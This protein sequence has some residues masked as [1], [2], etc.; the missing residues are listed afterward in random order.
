[1]KITL[2]DGTVIESKRFKVTI[3]ENDYRFSL[4]FNNGLVVNKFNIY[5]SNIIIQPRVTNEIIIH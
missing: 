1:M 5:D 3:E 4:G 2:E